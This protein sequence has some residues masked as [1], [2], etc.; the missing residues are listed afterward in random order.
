ME[1]KI[2]KNWF[3]SHAH[4]QSLEKYQSSNQ[5]NNQDEACQYIQALESNSYNEY[6]EIVLF[7]KKSKQGHSTTESIMLMVGLVLSIGTSISLGVY[8]LV[9]RRKLWLRR[10]R[11][12]MP[13]PSTPNS[14]SSR[15]KSNNRKKQAWDSHDD[16]F[17]DNDTMA[18]EESSIWAW[19]RHRQEQRRKAGRWSSRFRSATHAPSSSWRSPKQLDT[20]SQNSILTDVAATAAT[21]VASSG[22]HHHNQMKKKTTNPKATTGP[23]KYDKEIDNNDYHD[24]KHHQY[25]RHDDQDDDDDQQLSRTSSTS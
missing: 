1:K 4:N 22:F 12:W 17:T 16:D 7:D 18:E 24:D 13:P 25:H 2:K 5:I 20:G 15:S 8:A 3:Y 9:L 19:N 10:K 11:L 6:G 23:E 14:S 21:V